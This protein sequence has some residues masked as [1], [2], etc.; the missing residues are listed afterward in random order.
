VAELGPDSRVVAVVGAAASPQLTFL[1]VQRLEQNLASSSRYQVLARCPPGC[2]A[3]DA[4]LELAVLDV[5]LVP[6]EAKASRAKEGRLT[7]RVR[8]IRRDGVLLWARDVTRSRSGGVPG[9]KDEVADDKVLSLCAAAAADR[10]FHDLHPSWVEDSFPLEKGG[11]L[12]G[13]AEAAVK[14]DLDRAEAIARQVAASEPG[15]AGAHYDLGALH[16]V[17]GQLEAAVVEF[18]AAAALDSRFA[19][20]VADAEQRLQDRR[21]VQQAR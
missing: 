5:A 3:A 9:H 6:G 10:V 7:L 2:P 17:R 15:N 21:A 19:D 8:A 16:T 1:A 14:G 12:A 20:D 13:C 4:L 11:L 18:R